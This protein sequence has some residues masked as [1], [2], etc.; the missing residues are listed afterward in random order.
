M[1]TLR[2]KYVHSFVD[3]TGRARFYFRYCGR[4]WPLP[5]EPGTAEFGERYDTH[6]GVS[7]SQLRRTA[8]MSSSVPA[9]WAK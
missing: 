4:R 9:L 1:A 5:G 8:I 7:V 2:L 3:K 6:C